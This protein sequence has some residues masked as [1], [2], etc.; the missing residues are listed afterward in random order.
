MIYKLL[1]I[2]L[3]VSTLVFICACSSQKEKRLEQALLF[4]GKNRGELEKVLVHYNNDLEKLEAARFLIRNM[5]R[6]YEYKVW[7]LDSIKPTLIQGVKDG[8][9]AKEIIDKWIGISW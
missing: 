7:Q 9:I 2:G 1:K 3:I 4:A 8:F 5:P 6:W